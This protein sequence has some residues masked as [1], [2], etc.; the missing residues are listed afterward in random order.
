MTKV[1]CDLD[2]DEWMYKVPLKI[3]K[4][5]ESYFPKV[6][7]IFEREPDSN[8]II[9][10]D[11][12][13]GNRLKVV[14]NKKIIN[15]KIKWVHFGSVGYE[16]VLMS[17]L[18]LSNLII[19]NSHNTMDSG[20]VNHALFLIF[21]L[22]RAGYGIEEIRKK[23]KL[24]RF[25]FEPYT[26]K[27]LSIE[28]SNILIIGLGEIG[29][30]LGKNL[31]S[32]GAN[33]DGV[34]KNI[35]EQ[36][37]KFIRKIFALNDLSKIISNYDMVISLLPF[38][39]SLKHI[40]DVHFFRSMKKNS[41]FINLGRG[42]HVNENDLIDALKLNLAAAAI[43]VF[44]KEP[45]EKNSKLYKINNLILS[46]HVAAYDPNYWENQYSL[47]KNNL[48]CFLNSKFYKMKN[49]IKIYS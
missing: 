32:L 38:D 23:K 5:L 46:P 7:F 31:Y 26:K 4:S 9:D 24:N 14:S 10:C 47:F 37:F 13:W 12:Y 19:T 36:K 11:I 49:I 6:K 25:S 21:S 35:S 44:E 34:K 39:N 43:D 22:L 28:K 20:M 3:R 33:V 41:F 16:R 17:N 2:L 48:E 15:Q 40:Y 18:N 8:Q 1:L 27:I 42:M 30:K 45:L 29:S